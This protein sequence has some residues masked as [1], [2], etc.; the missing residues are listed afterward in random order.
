LFSGKTGIPRI[1]Q[2]KMSD[3]G[4]VPACHGGIKT[5]QQ[6]LRAAG[7]PEIRYSI[8]PFS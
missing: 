4:K 5:F 2:S 8:S 7:S 6:P 1:D 3:D